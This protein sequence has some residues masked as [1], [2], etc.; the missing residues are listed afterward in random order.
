MRVAGSQGLNNRIDKVGHSRKLDETETKLTSFVPA[1]RSR[2]I[3]HELPQTLRV[4]L[5]DGEGRALCAG[6]DVAEVRQGG[7][8]FDR[9][10]G[11]TADCSVYFP[12]Q[13][14]EGESIFRLPI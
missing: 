12:P 13:S 2:Q 14:R 6:G 9:R 1:L 11:E 10:F 8:R 4:L 7:W 3:Y 5:L